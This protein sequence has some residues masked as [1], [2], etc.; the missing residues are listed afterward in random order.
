M[1]ET[2]ESKET[3]F[4]TASALEK[5]VEEMLVDGAIDQTFAFNRQ[6]FIP[7][8]AA[9]VELADKLAQDVPNTD[10]F[11]AQALQQAAQSLQQPVNSLI[12]T[13]KQGKLLGELV[14]RTGV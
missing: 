5:N 2:T 4:Q 8:T 10:V 13:E 11:V 14:Q 12:K 9:K 6:Q 7:L 3:G 1:I